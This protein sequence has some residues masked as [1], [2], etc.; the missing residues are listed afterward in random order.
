MDLNTKLNLFTQFYKS[1][2]NDQS[3]I[4]SSCI[5]I[6]TPARRLVDHESKK[7]FT[8]KYSV[9]LLGRKFEVCKAG[10][11]DIFK[12]TSSRLRTLQHKMEQGELLPKD[13][14]GVHHNRPHQV[15]EEVKQNIRNHINMFPTYETHYARKDGDPL[16]LYLAPELSI[17]KMYD[18]YI[19][20]ARENTLAECEKWIYRDIFKSEFKLRFGNPKL[21][22]CDN[23][24]KFVAQLNGCETEAQRDIIKTKQNDH[25]TLS[26]INFNLIQV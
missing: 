25:H 22:S 4:L 16:R 20:Y 18:L 7:K 24:D 2:Y 17:G 21:D 11:M 23:C 1:S 13:R 14:R 9:N 26:K 3:A 12:V 5:D 8:Y 10:L 15:S 6:T 19:E